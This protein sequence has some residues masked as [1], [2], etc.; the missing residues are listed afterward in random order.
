MLHAIETT[1]PPLPE[2]GELTQ[3][4]HQAATELPGH[5]NADIVSMRQQATRLLSSTGFP[6]KKTESWH[7]TPVQPLAGFY[8]NF[9][10]TPFPTEA[11]QALAKTALSQLNL[12]TNSCAR[13]V[14][15]DGFLI[16]ELGHD[17]SPSALKVQNWRQSLSGNPETGSQS[18][19]GD[20][21]NLSRQAD[22]QSHYSKLAHP[23]EDGFSLLNF[24]SMQDGLHLDL[25]AGHNL[26]QPVEIIA[27][28][29]GTSGATLS[30]THKIDLGANSHL[31]IVDYHLSLVPDASALVT[32]QIHCQ[33]A[34]G[35]NLS[36]TQVMSQK[37]QNHQIT[38]LNGTV[39][40]DAT[41]K[42][43]SFCA[44][45]QMLRQEAFIRLQGENSFCDLSALYLSS[46]TQIHDHTFRV[47]HEA[48]NTNSKQLVKGLATD[49]AK[50]IFQGQI[51]VAKD[52]QHIEGNQLSR[53]LLLSDKAS[54]QCKPELEIFANDVACSHGATIGDLDETALFYL[55]SRGIPALEAKKILTFAFIE[56]VLEEACFEALQPILHNDIDQ[57]LPALLSTQP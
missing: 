19:I 26:D 7:F 37:T 14:F 5:K 30:Q 18:P 6:N 50:A 46:G 27:M 22:R 36:H 3:R 13:F 53:G 41:L 49:Q 16:T 47:D 39:A 54:I 40:A 38:R 21:Y 42:S 57:A 23:T 44:G 29:S 32:Q 11:V 55:R 9:Q 24:A 45:A 56:E 43:F 52:A 4:L 2:L 51:L 31:T 33:L 34:D 35:A 48:A 28:T 8:Q 20:L 12:L 25:A 10:M 1:A 15:L 17:H